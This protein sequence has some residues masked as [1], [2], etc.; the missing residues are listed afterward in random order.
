MLAGVVARTRVAATT[1]HQHQHRHEDGSLSGAEAMQVKHVAQLILSGSEVAALRPLLSDIGTG[2]VIGGEGTLDGGEHVDPDN[3]KDTSRDANTDRKDE[4]SSLFSRLFGASL[5]PPPPLPPLSLQS[6]N[7]PSEFRTLFKPL[8]SKITCLQ[9]ENLTSDDSILSV[10][11][12]A[13]LEALR[14][15]SSRPSL[16]TNWPHPSD[17]RITT[18][19]ITD[20]VRPSPASSASTTSTASAAKFSSDFD[21]LSDLTNS[22]LLRFMLDAKDINSALFT[23]ISLA[24][25]GFSSVPRAL[26]APM[27]SVS[28]TALTHLSMRSNSIEVIGNLTSKGLFPNLKTLDLRDNNICD[29]FEI[30]GCSPLESLT[31]LLVA[32]NSI[33]RHESHR[34]NIFTYFG[35]RANSL[36]IDNFLPTAAEKKEILAG[37]TIAASSSNATRVTVKSNN[38]LQTARIKSSDLAGSTP[39]RKKKFS[40]RRKSRKAVVEDLPSEEVQNLNP[41]ASLTTRIITETGEN[42]DLMMESMSSD[43]SATPSDFASSPFFQNLRHADANAATPLD[44]AVVLRLD[45]A[46]FYSDSSAE[47]IH[48]TLKDDT[49]GSAPI[50]PAAQNRS[51]SKYYDAPTDFAPAGPGSMSGGNSSS[52]SSDDEGGTGTTASFLADRPDALSS[53]SASPIHPDV[54]SVPG[55]MGPSPLRSSSTAQPTH[56]NRLDLIEE[57][58]AMAVGRRSPSQLEDATFMKRRQ[59]PVTA[60]KPNFPKMKTLSFD[61]VD[62]RNSLSSSPTSGGFAPYMKS[63]TT[64]TPLANTPSQIRKNSAPSAESGIPFTS[65]TL[66]EADTASEWQ[67]RMAQVQEAARKETQ[68][69]ADAGDETVKLSSSEKNRGGFED[70]AD[71]TT[72]LTQGQ[73]MLHF[74]GA[75]K[76]LPRIPMRGE[77]GESNG[78]EMAPRLIL[79]RPV[80]TNSTVHHRRLQEGSDFGSEASGAASVYSSFHQRQTSNSR[81]G[82]G[83]SGL[84]NSVFSGDSAGFSVFS[85]MTGITRSSGMPLQAG[86]DNNAAPLAYPRAPNVPFLSINNSLQLHLKFNVFAN[87]QEKILSWVAGSIVPQVSPYLEGIAGPPTEQ[88]YSLLG[89]SSV[90][91]SSARR[92]FAKDPFILATKERMQTVERAGYILVTDKALY[93]FTPTFV[94]PYN[95]FKT[96]TASTAPAHMS[97]VIAQVR[98]DDPSRTLKL[99]RR[100]PLGNLARVD[101][102][103]NR[104]YLSLHFLAG[105]EKA[106]SVTRGT[107]SGGIGV[108]GSLKMGRA[109]TSSINHEK[110]KKLPLSGIRSVVFLTRDRTATSRIIDNLVPVLYESRIK[111]KFN[112][113]GEDGKLKIVNQDVE[114]SL[115]ALRSTVLLKQG[116]FKD[117]VLNQVEVDGRLDWRNILAKRSQSTEGGSSE[118]RSW[119]SGLLSSPLSVGG[120]SAS[121]SSITPTALGRRNDAVVN[122]T[123][124]DCA[125]TSD[126]IL[127]KYGRSTLSF[128]N[129]TC[130]WGGLYLTKHL[131]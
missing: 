52:S 80:T 53:A 43:R 2:T 18:L 31:E 112:L 68:Q 74:G 39:E 121:S 96:A 129:C 46:R 51:L 50:P 58:V 40:N 82:M 28:F 15:V 27:E 61:V 57:T 25:N 9:M 42:P 55:S 106:T 110:T 22:P 14:I 23:H 99:A 102:G 36:K 124:L 76:S 12:F 101:V 5:A 113:R 114:W 79:A 105:D 35:E 13:Q 84:A 67:R 120:G 49:Q 17:A 95:P 59:V 1:V 75:S 37:L 8:L 26:V 97:N 128:S 66:R 71:S 10:N 72:P 4:P 88:G 107:G 3:R 119:F 56:S 87:D 109:S 116:G 115:A 34:Q 122:E 69:L 44:D 60:A 91:S 24:R 63:S 64:I 48:S 83:R 81:P 41:L 100:I 6:L 85:G 131:Q 65:T 77:T 104:Q 111:S 47:N 30:K 62:S 108:E 89:G 70:L 103:P 98:Y 94:M 11:E 29:V 117:V 78:N 90:T 54:V 7:D 93:I 127:D 19:C 45:S 33:A 86:F 126:V 125:T 20:C 21:L 92:D 130:L 118:R 123:D 38:A 32:G 16:L 73:R